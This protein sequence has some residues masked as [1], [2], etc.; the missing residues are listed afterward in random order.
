MST[1]SH[2]IKQAT[3]QLAATSDSAQ[4]D[5]E[6]LM[7]AVLNKDRSYL[8]TWP[9]RDLEATAENHFHALL[10]RRVN[11][12]PIAHILGERHFWTLNLNVTK[13]TLI[14]RPETEL[15]VELALEM[16]PQNTP[17]QILDMGTGTGAIALSLASERPSSQ[18]TAT[19]VSL[20]ALTVAQQNALK[21]N[22][23]NVEFVQSHWFS[24]L[25]NKQ[26]DVIV[27][28][29]PYVCED[30]IHLSQGDVRFEPVTALTSGADGLNDIREI[31]Q[32]SLSHLKQQGVLLIEH[33]YDQSEAICELLNAADFKQ[34]RDVNDYN[35]QPRVAIGYICDENK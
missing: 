13:D 25:K 14:P 16:I 1:I 2:T 22:I 7:C 30:D 6:L 8:H 35:H 26:F 19:D 17:L 15:L 11:G 12:E 33:G 24:E 32:H 23:N 18:V 9:E 4:L 31:I 21:L 3:R 28:N 5:A 10:Q 34:V 20:A 27:S 29:P